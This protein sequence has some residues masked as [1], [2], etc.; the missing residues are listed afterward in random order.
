MNIVLRPRWLLIA[1]AVAFVAG[2]VGI[3]IGW[4]S[5]GPLG[6]LIAEVLAILAAILL[7]TP[8]LPPARDAAEPPPLTD[9]AVAVDHPLGSDDAATQSQ[10]TATSQR[11]H[12]D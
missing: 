4:S 1:A 8:A 12:P 9:S 3:G 2:S 6:L 7:T 11:Q 5:L 10:A